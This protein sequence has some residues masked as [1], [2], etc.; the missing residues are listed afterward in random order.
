MPEP[1]GALPTHSMQTLQGPSIVAPSGML[2]SGTGPLMVVPG[3]GEVHTERS[4]SRFLH[5]AVG[6]MGDGE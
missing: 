2:P 5:L 4:W 6:V 1:V 3:A